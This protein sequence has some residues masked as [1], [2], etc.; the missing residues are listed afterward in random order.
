MTTKMVAV[1]YVVP[2]ISINSVINRNKVELLSDGMQ[3]LRGA[4][5]IERLIQN[6]NDAEIKKYRV[7]Y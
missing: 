3:V 6:A 1:Y 5:I 2:S 7:G 4:E